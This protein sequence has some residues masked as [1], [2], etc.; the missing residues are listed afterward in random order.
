MSS[1]QQSNP[2]VTRLAEPARV[3]QK[4]EVVILPVSDVERAKSFYQRL[5]WRLDADFS[6][7]KDWHVMQMTPPGSPCS[8]LFGKGLTTAAPGSLQG[9]FL[10]VHDIEAARADLARRDVDVSEAFHFEGSFLR[11]TGTQ[12]R[13]PG[14]D[15]EGRSYLTFAAFSDPDGNTWLLQEITTR[16]PGRGLGNLDVAALTALLRETEKRHGEFEPGAPE[17]HWSDWYAAFM[18]ALQEGKTPE[19]AAKA[20]ALHVE[21]DR[22]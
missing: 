7:G 13:V 3:E 15:P 16:L 12:G 22:R 10:V 9:S 1:T 20:G 11:A 17:H 6:N 18:V 21:R 19:E 2:P 5:G 4:L 8:V 14:R